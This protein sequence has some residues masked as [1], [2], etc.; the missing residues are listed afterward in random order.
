MEKPEIENLKNEN[1]RLEQENKALKK[2]VR[3]HFLNVNQFVDI[4]AKMD[5]LLVKKREQ[6]SALELQLKNSISEVEKY[7]NETN[8]K[9][10]DFSID[11]DSLAETKNRYEPKELGYTEEKW[12]KPILKMDINGY[13]LCPQSDTFDC[14]YKSRIKCNIYTH[15]FTH[16]GEKPYKCNFCEF[17]SSQLSCTKTHAKRH[18]TMDAEMYSCTVCDRK[19]VQSTDL[20]R[21]AKN[22]HGGKGWQSLKRKRS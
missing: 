7:K 13:Y 16:T 10:E 3:N 9:L 11:I 12:T 19:F 21:H 5:D 2:V 1:A 6:I 4:I 17:K 14:S 18:G 20:R 15:N 8:F 22:A